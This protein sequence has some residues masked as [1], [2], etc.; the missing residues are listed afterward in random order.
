MTRD[1]PDELRSCVSVRR[2]AAAGETQAGPDAD[3][4]GR[5]R[6]SDP[7]VYTLLEVPVTDQLPDGG[8]RPDAGSNNSATH[9]GMIGPAQLSQARPG[10]R[11]R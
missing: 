6:A 7:G 3:A 5:L 11:V 4:R 8:L 1:T 2:D 9:A 10:A